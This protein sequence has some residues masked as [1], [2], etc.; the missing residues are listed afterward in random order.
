MHSANSVKR[1]A[2]VVAVAAAA[3]GI[4]VAGGSSAA[5]APAPDAPQVT[6]SPSTNLSEG[7]PITVTVSGF[8]AAQKVHFS[9]CAEIGGANVCDHDG[10]G[11]ITTDGNGGGSSASVAHKTFV[12][13]LDNGTKW[14]TVDCK[15]AEHGC[16]V[17]AGADDGTGATT[18]IS[19]S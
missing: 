3:F 8:K 2:G 1:V 12:G 4:A 17:G 7:T 19:F 9:E 13:Y 15:T 10:S 6:V 16:Y 18:V 11:Q 5:A 14:G